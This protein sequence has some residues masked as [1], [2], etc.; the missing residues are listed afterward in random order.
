MNVVEI[1]QAIEA[2]IVGL[3][4]QL[5]CLHPE[6][7]E[8]IHQLEKALGAL[9]P[10]M[11]VAAAPVAPVPVNGAGR[12]RDR[13]LAALAGGP[14]GAR[15]AM[16]IAEVPRVQFYNTITDL[17]KA[18]KIRKYGKRPKTVYEIVR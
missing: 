9:G 4:I 8:E 2:R 17:L 11:P 6:I 15:E 1:R 7:A 18:G 10:E 12:P 3:E 16:S 5:Q 13:I 14:M